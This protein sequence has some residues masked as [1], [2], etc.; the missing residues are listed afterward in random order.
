MERLS[1]GFT[2]IE[3]LIAIF[4][5]SLISVGIVMTVSNL[6]SAATRQGGLLADQD[7]ARKLIFQATN[8]LRNSVAGANGAY[9]LESVGNQQ[10]IFFTNADPSTV[11]TERVRYYLQNGKIYKGITKYSGGVYNTSTEQTLLM[12]NN[13][14]SST[15]PLFYYYDGN[16]IGSS[17]QSALVQ[18]VSVA[19]VKFIK[20]D[21]RIFN[22]AGVQNQNSYSVTGGAAIRSVKNNLGQ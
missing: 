21:V 9:Q 13:I 11:T 20:M 3:V 10:L 22:K 8:E 1:G 14:A 7:Q 5:F 16:Y 18:P 4:I 17:T 2:L 19:S 15:A 6:F 12:Q